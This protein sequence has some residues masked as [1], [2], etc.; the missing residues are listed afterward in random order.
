MRNFT[1]RQFLTLATAAGGSLFLPRLGWARSLLSAGEEREAHF[2]LQ[3]VLPGGIDSS[4]FFDAR[5]LA[6][7][8]AGKIQNYLGEEA[9]PHAGTNGTSCLRSPL[10]NPLAPLLSRL[11]IVNGVLMMPSFDG[12]DQNMNFLVTGSPFGGDSFLPH[13][14]QRSAHAAPS[15]LDGL[16]NGVSYVDA[17]NHGGMVPL[18]PGSLNMLKGK[19]GE[20][21]KNE[22]TDL[23][24][25]LRSRLLANSQGAGSFSAGARAMLRAFDAIPQLREKIRGLPAPDASISSDRQ[26]VQLLGGAFR[27]GMARSA[28]WTINDEFDTH[29]PEQAAR[30][31]AMF[32]KL[33]ARFSEILNALVD[34]P[35]DENRSLLDVTTVMISSEFS[36]SM[37]QTGSRV[38]N[39]GTDHN[40]V[41]NMFLFAGKGIRAGQVLG[42]TDYQSAEERLS[43]AHLDFDAEKIKMIGRPFDFATGRPADTL[44]GTLDPA[45]YLTVGSLINSVYSLFGVPAA[46]YRKH[47]RAEITAPVL[48]QL[49]S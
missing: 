5:P 10:T 3:I 36:R 39:T 15:P 17:S 42:A 37:L 31:P 24:R 30:Q 48:R 27:S 19:L 18:D 16:L 43:K 7:T 32:R 14:N 44:P 46:L 25:F 8:A 45:L 1:R 33:I 22:E 34:T 2:F 13:L 12:H 35:F 11:T 9:I 28:L 21:P 26:F 23:D 38:N 6:M 20:M 47:E 49:L 40:S 29:S 4:Y 41:S